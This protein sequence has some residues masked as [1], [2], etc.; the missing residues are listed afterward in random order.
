MNN[1]YLN[2]TYNWEEII[3]TPLSLEIAR[4]KAPSLTDED[5][6]DQIA[7]ALHESIHLLYAVWDD[8]YVNFV[9]VSTRKYGSVFWKGHKVKGA[10]LAQDYN[11][12]QPAINSTCAAALFELEL[13]NKNVNYNVE[14]E[15]EIAL[16]AAKH[17][18]WPEPHDD[19]TAHKIVVSTLNTQT[20]NVYSTEVGQLG[21]LWWLV[22]S[23]A[24]A[25]LASRRKTDGRVTEKNTRKICEFVYRFCKSEKSGTGEFFPEFRQHRTM[26]EDIF[27]LRQILQKNTI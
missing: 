8:I 4:F 7:T 21:H 20:S 19:K 1:F 12:G 27:W 24:I 5:A 9:G 23:I 6:A 13:N 17:L 14:T 11:S 10:T 25:I 18:K 3:K 16:K 15:I 2:N 26:N 22:R